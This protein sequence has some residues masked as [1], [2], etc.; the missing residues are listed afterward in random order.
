MDFW[1]ELFRR[2]YFPAISCCPRSWD[3]ESAPSLK[4]EENGAGRGGGCCFWFRL[5]L[6][7]QEGVKHVL[8][9]T[10]LSSCANPGVARCMWPTCW[11]TCHAPCMQH[12]AGMGHALHA[13]PCWTSYVHWLWGLSR[14]GHAR[15]K[16]PHSTVW[17]GCWLHVAS[18]LTSD[19]ARA[20]WAALAPCWLLMRTQQAPGPWVFHT[21]WNGLVQGPSFSAGCAWHPWPKQLLSRCPYCNVEIHFHSLGKEG[22][23]QE[24]LNVHWGVGW[25]SALFILCCKL[26]S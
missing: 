14:L 8:W 4:L 25:L 22:D 12:G 2:F 19:P 18:G 6:P 3:W 23:D 5:V 17:L 10:G 24:E 9:V 1:P 20:P 13:T 21:G 16:E 15:A 11:V 26:L 7:K